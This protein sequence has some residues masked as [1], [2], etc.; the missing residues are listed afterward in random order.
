V[1][2]DTWLQNTWD[3]FKSNFWFLPT[4]MSLSAMAAC[5]L[6]LYVDTKT[7]FLFASLGAGSL[8]T[9][10]STLAV[11]IGTLVT[12][13]SIAFSSTVVVLTLAALELGPKLLR[14]YV[15]TGATRH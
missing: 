9:M 12:A 3:S 11:L 5:L 1:K 8:N 13:L 7:G 6:L 4:N 14:I 15:R 2:R 10:R